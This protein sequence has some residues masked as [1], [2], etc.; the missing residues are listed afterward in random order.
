[1]TEDE[2]EQKAIY[3]C[4]KNEVKYLSHEFYSYLDKNLWIAVED[5]SGRYEIKIKI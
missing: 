2:V 1:M 5:Y 3:W 4:I